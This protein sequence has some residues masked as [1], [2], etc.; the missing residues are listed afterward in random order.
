MLT[1]DLGNCSFDTRDFYEKEPI[2]IV[3]SLLD[4]SGDPCNDCGVATST[5]G[6]MSTTSGETVLRALLLTESYMQNPYNQ[7][8][9][10][11]ARI[12]EIELSDDIVGAVDRSALY[13]VWQ[14]QHSVPRFNNPTGVFDNDQYVYHFYV[15]CGDENA[16]PAMAEIFETIRNEANQLGNPIEVESIGVCGGDKRKNKSNYYYI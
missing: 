15:K 2:S 10:D 12:R 13:E 9:K 16:G 11:S 5:P 3:L 8:N 1:L 14:L 6:K 4:E 7:G